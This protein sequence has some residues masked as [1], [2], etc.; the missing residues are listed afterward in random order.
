M[1]QQASPKV[2]GQ[3]EPFLAQFTAFSR[4]P[5]MTSGVPSLSCRPSW[6]SP[7]SIPLQ[8]AFSPGIHIGNDEQSNKDHHFNQS[9]HPDLGEYDGPRI[10]KDHFNVEDDEQHCKYV[11]PNWERHASV[12]K[13]FG[14]TFVGR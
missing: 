9:N 4:D 12:G 8:R 11:I 14:P 7:I 2:I 6:I 5:V 13:R 10:E 1:A 3:R